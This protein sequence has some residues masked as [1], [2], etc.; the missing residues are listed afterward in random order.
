MATVLPSAFYLMKL[1]F[2]HLGHQ[3]HIQL[4]QNKLCLTSSPDCWLGWDLTR[5]GDVFDAK[6]A[7]GKIHLPESQ[8]E[9]DM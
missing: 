4:R 7:R 9:F 8:G 3:C 5:L 1:R 2:S 6:A